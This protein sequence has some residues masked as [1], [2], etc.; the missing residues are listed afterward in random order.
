MTLETL[1]AVFAVLYVISGAAERLI[2]VF[3]F[4]F[5]KITNSDVQSSIKLLSAILIG[6]G[7]SAL[8]HFDLLAQVGII[9]V[10]AL[11]GYLAAGLLSSVGSTTISWFLAWLKTLKN[12]TTVTK[13]T[14]GKTEQTVVVTETVSTKAPADEAL[15]K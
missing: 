12:D 6:V 4:L 7:L 5:N 8:F 11:V 13:T 9:G 14:E 10:S 2:E 1:I 15:S 3:K